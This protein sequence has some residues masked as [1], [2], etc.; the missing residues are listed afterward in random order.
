M[1]SYPIPTLTLPKGEGTTTLFE[2]W[3]QQGMKEAF[4]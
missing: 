4:I 1:I 3:E 2:V